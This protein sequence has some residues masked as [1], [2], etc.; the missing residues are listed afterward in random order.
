MLLR[1]HYASQMCGFVFFIK[2]RKAGMNTING[3]PE[4]I[5]SCKVQKLVLVKNNVSLQMPGPSR[6]LSC[7]LARLVDSC[8]LRLTC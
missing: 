8:P 4:K 1:I 3:G 7:R 2:L 6:H 5:Q